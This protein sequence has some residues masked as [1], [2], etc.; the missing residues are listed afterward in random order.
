[1][2]TGTTL[3]L[4][5]TPAYNSYASATDTRPDRITGLITV[6]PAKFKELQRLFFISG[7]V[8][9][10]NNIFVFCSVQLIMSSTDQN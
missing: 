6:T 8:S 5:A 4:L 9:N 3:L 2:C 1:M 10:Y 7:G